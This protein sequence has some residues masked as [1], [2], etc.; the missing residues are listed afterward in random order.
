MLFA[1]Q[2]SSRQVMA[3]PA[4]LFAFQRKRVSPRACSGVYTAWQKDAL[5]TTAG[6]LLLPA[7]ARAM[8]FLTSW[9]GWLWPQLRAPRSGRDDTSWLRLPPPRW[10]WHPAQSNPGTQRSAGPGTQRSPGTGTQRSPGPRFQQEDLG[11]EESHANL[12]TAAT[13]LPL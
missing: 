10:P 8:A 13:F 4:L 1:F 5:K 11:V 2:A 3:L 6:S 9:E 12:E 7:H